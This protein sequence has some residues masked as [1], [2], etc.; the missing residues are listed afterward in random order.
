[1]ALPGVP[2]GLTFRRGASSGRYPYFESLQA[3][4]RC[5]AAYSLRSQ[6]EL[7][8]Y[9]HGSGRPPDVNYDPVV[10]AARVVIKAG[11]VSLDNDV[12]LPIPEHA[13]QSLFATWDLWMAKEFAIELTGIGNYKHF[14]FLSRD[15]I[16]VEPKADWDSPRRNGQLAEVY[17]RYY[18]SKSFGE[19]GPNITHNNPVKPYNSWAMRAETWMRYAFL[20]APT[21]TVAMIKYTDGTVHEH[22]WWAFSWWAMHAGDGGFHQIYDRALVVPNY[23]NAT[24]WHKLLVEYNTSTANPS[25][26][27]TERHSLIRNFAFLRGV[28]DPLPLLEPLR[29]A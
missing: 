28:T 17:A 11:Q 20:F 4:P 7:L 19:W 23:P 14:N 12:V 10:D 27:L 3:D 21:T 26:T 1:M 25:P 22:T 15:R 2:G 18:G 16:W 8:R 13:P 24:G 29:A 9:R 6:D 5:I